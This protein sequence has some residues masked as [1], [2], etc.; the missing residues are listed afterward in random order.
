MIFA[1]VADTYPPMKSSGAIQLRDLSEE[2][3]KQGFEIYMLIADYS[4]SKPWEI[5]AANNVTI[6]RLKTFKTRA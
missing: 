1:I 6:I 3:T 4:L 5:E 2:F